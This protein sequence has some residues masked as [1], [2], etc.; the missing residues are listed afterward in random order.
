MVY[1]SSDQRPLAYCRQIT[2][3]EYEDQRTLAGSH[4]FL[5]QLLE[6]IVSDAKLTPKNRK[7]KL[8]DVS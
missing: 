2:H 6:Q 3:Q 7:K 5:N 8:K 4:F 1:G